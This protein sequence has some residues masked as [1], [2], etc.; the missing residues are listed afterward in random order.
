L[1]ETAPRLGITLAP[2]DFALHLLLSLVA[3]GV[4]ALVP[5]AAHT[6]QRSVQPEPGA[7]GFLALVYGYL[8]LV[9][10]GTL[11]HY[12]DLGLFEAGRL[13]PVAWQTFGATGT[14]SLPVLVA[15]PA[16][17]AFLQG[18]ALVAGVLASVWLTQKIARQT[19]V[20]QLPQHLATLALAAVLWNLIVGV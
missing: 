13:L 10:G 4:P 19:F 12:L 17:I 16:V 18:T 11:A 1:E 7:P 14:E 2:D 20:R 8:P 9:L 15:H 3:L 6:L 5:L